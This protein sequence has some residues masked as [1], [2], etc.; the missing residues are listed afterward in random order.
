MK[1]TLKEDGFEAALTAA[2]GENKIGWN[3]NDHARL[4]DGVL[5]ALVD[6]KGNPVVVPADQKELAHLAIAPNPG[7]Q[8]TMVHRAFREAGVELD[9]DTMKT[10]ESLIGIQ[11][12][13]D[14]L[15]DS[16]RITKAEK[17]GRKM[18]LAALLA[19]TKA[20]A[21]AV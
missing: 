2:V 11:Q 14:G 21:A 7:L 19:K 10:M 5:S 12:F 20:T 3:T 18:A 9:A 17:A 8:R 4:L 13:G 1:T 16:K 15:V 6:E